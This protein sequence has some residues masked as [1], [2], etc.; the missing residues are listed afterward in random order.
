MPASR[1]CC[2]QRTH[3]EGIFGNVKSAKTSDL[4]RGWI[5]IVGMR[6]RRWPG[7]NSSLPWR[8]PAGTATDSRRSQRRARPSRMLAARLHHLS[9]CPPLHQS[10]V[11]R[12]EGAVEPARVAPRLALSAWTVQSSAA[13]GGPQTAGSLFKSGI[14]SKCPSCV[15]SSR[16]CARAVAAIH[17]SA[18]WAGCPMAWPVRRPHALNA[19]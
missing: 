13:L 10:R 16:S 9:R 15:A 6:L 18:T 3:V 4:Q 14:P 17:R 7:R 12:V 5:F 11:K 8:M 1:T 2:R 19:T